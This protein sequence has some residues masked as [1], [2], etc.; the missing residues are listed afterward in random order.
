MSETFDVISGDCLIEMAK[1]AP[2]SFDSIVSDPPYG[3]KFMGKAWDHGVPGSPFWIEALRVTKPGAYMVAFGGT[4]TYHR[5]AV[6]IEDAGW[7]IRDCITWLYGSG[8]PKSLNLGEGRGTALK[9]AWEPII[10]ARK[11]FKGTVA[12]NVERHA[13]GALNIDGCRIA[14]EDA[15]YAKN[16]SGDRGHTDSARASDF[17]MTAGK[18]SDVGR[19][20]ANVVLDEDA[21]G[22]LDRAAPDTGARTD[23]TGEGPGYQQRNLV[24]GAFASDHSPFGIDQRG[25][26]SRFFYTAKASRSEREEGLDEFRK[27]P[28]GSN[29]KGYTADVARGQ[30]RNR[31]VANNH[32]TVKPLD[33]MRW[34]CRLVTP[35]K[36][37]ILDPFTGSGS[38]GCAA[39]SEGFSFVGI[40]LDPDYAALATKRI[41]HHGRQL[42]LGIL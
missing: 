23:A 29:A 22:V 17:A 7:E 12:A 32:P 18:A 14:V 38:T 3:L 33:L 5:L 41:E 24:Y 39:L 36:G 42:T 40:E 20:P 25:G 13:T 28:G 30:D 8:F 31:P 2:E 26:A 21:A 37:K 9:P 4:R 27:T 34:L 10:L 19:W 6:A 11:P 35:P 1:L 15:S 16:A